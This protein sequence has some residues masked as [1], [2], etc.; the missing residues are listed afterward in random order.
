MSEKEFSEK[1]EFGIL[2]WNFK[3]KDF[4]DVDIERKIQKD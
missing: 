4:T 2:I 1:S 3:K